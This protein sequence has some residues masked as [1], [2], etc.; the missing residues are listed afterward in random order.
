ML[1][2]SVLVPTYRRPHG[3]H[4]CLDAIARQTRPPD[5]VLVVVRDTDQETRDY[6]ADRAPSSLVIRPV[7]VSTPGLVAALNAGLDALG[8]DLVACT[9]DDARPHPEW[10]A[11]IG[12]HFESDPR[13]GAVG[14]RDWIPGSR[15][16]GERR[17]VGQLQWWG[18]IVGNHHLGVGPPRD[19]DVLKGVNMSYRRAAL[20]G[21]RF[22]TRLLGAGS[23]VHNELG[24]TFALRR[25]GWRVI[26]D[27]AV[28]V[29]HDQAPR[30]DEAQRGD[31][32]PRAVHD[33]VHNETLALLE[34]LPAGRRELF[35]LWALTV[36]T[37]AAPGLAQWMRFLAKG[38]PS[39]TQRLLASWQGRWCAWRRWRNHR[40]SRERPV[41]VSAAG[42]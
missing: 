35:L 29:D 9:D 6:L 34:H 30:V 26:Y 1:T 14:G 5:D 16:D 42:K 17:V 32:S 25:G 21:R 41:P 22:D 10:L 7:G 15:L 8:T 3:L 38:W 19:V 2:I 28:A 36:G 37:R 23:T 33:A 18:R 24:V 4:R 20:A 11:R 12:W 13:I 31:F 27:P 39:P 40:H